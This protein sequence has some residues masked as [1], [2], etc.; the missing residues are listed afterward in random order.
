MD[1][2][3][4]CL[5]AWVKG[6]WILAIPKH[7]P[8][9]T[10]HKSIMNFHL[11]VSISQQRG[12]VFFL[13]QI[14]LKGQYQKEALSH[15]TCRGTSSHKAPG[16]GKVRASVLVGCE[17]RARWQSKWDISQVSLVHASSSGG[18]REHCVLSLWLRWNYRRPFC[19]VFSPSGLREDNERLISFMN[20]DAQIPNKV[21][22]NQKFKNM[23]K[24]S[25]IL[26]NRLHSRKAKLMGCTLINK[27]DIP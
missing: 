1:Y 3:I 20:I 26:P 5:V 9:R 27:C 21:L 6:L 15:Q 24:R 13:S 4:V 18:N 22:E 23:S 14:L 16:G 12:Y 11:C 19:Q 8:T 10:I 17:D 2:V 25:C 7:C